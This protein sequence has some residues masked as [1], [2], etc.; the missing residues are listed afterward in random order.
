MNASG[1][2]LLARWVA[3][4]TTRRRALGLAVAGLALGSGDTIAARQ[5]TP[6]PDATPVTETEEPVFLFVQTAASGRGELNPAAGTPT[7]DGTPV[8]GGGASLRLTL[9]GHSGQTIYFS[10]RPNRIVG[11]ARTQQFLHELGFTTMDPPNAALVA[12]F[13]SG[14]GIVV[15]ELIEPAYDP[16]TGTLTYGAELLEGYEGE[17]LEP[18][19]GKQVIERL[20]AEFGSAALFID[21]G[22]DIS[23]WDV[24]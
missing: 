23:S 8:A 21:S 7:V 2:D 17:N 19:V 1:F 12:E 14:Q 6:A 4:S 10:D 5:A 22:R 24:G 16:A 11:A 20:P 15:L 18:V 13:A 9:S 3:G